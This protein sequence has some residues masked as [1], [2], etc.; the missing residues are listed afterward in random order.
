MNR[1]QPPE[2]VVSFGQKESGSLDLLASR[3]NL[4]K[5][6]MG[7]E[8]YEHF[9]VPTLNIDFMGRGMSAVSK[10]QPRFTSDSILS[11]TDLS[12]R[13][14]RNSFKNRMSLNFL[15]FYQIVNKIRSFRELQ[16]S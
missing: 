6:A 13:F 1:S 10:F 5:Q 12:A 7:I 11:Q 4:L 14:Y 3:Y 8:A 15:S 9:H 16:F 2:T